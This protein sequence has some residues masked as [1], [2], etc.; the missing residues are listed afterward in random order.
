VAWATSFTPTDALVM[1]LAWKQRT[2][3]WVPAPDYDGTWSKACAG[4]HE[5]GITLA[6]DGNGYVTRYS[7]A[8][9]ERGCEKWH[10]PA[11]DH[12]ATFD[13]RYIVN[14]R[15]LTAQ[16]AREVC[17]QC[18]SQGVSSASPAGVY[19]SAWNDQSA[20]GG[21]NFIP[22]VHQLFDFMV[23][24]SFGDPDFYWPAGFPA[25][26]HLTATDFGAS[27]HVSNPCWKVTCSDCHSAHSGAGG[28]AEFAQTDA[29]GDQHDFQDNAAAL[30]DDVVCLACHA[31]QGAFRFLAV[32]D[33]AAYPLSLGGMVL[34]N[35]AAWSASASDQETA[36]DLVS[37]LVKEHMAA[38]SGC[39]APFDP[40]GS[41]ARRQ[42]AAPPATCPGP[43]SRAPT[44][45][46]STRAGTRPASSATSPPTPLP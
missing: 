23:G 39:T 32:A 8:D 43:P 21:G 42:G 14:P 7:A 16:A 33:A 46:A 28:P 10:G 36:A 1:P 18:H 9:R 25:A 31:G 26:D 24:P 5:A 34:R 4:C 27:A 20:T 40:V 3:Q 19:G 15:Y 41:G 35:G 29:A 22:G 30:R 13:P 11:S 12:V 37:T 44:S 17:A 2:Q 38:Q 45:P 6:A